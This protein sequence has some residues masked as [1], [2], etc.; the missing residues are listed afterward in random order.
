MHKIIQ[1]APV[2]QI[3]PTFDDTL[4]SMLATAEADEENVN[5]WHALEPRTRARDFSTGRMVKVLSKSPD[6]G[7]WIE[8]VNVHGTAKP[9]KLAP[10]LLEPIS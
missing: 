6:E 9:Y 3:V 1:A 10:G 8:V 4:A 5:A 7:D 2:G